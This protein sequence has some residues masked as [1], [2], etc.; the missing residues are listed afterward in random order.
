MLT[1]T[2]V[3]V[4]NYI[5]AINGDNPIHVR[6]VFSSQGI[7]LDDQD[8]DISK[9]LVLEDI[10][11]GDTDIAFGKAVMKQ[12]T[13]GILN[14]NRVSSLV[15]T[16]EF[17]L[18]IGVD[19]N[20]TTNYVKVGTFIGKQPQSINISK[21]INFTA[22]DRMVKFDTLADEFFEAI[23]YPTTVQDI[24]DDLCTF[25]GVTNVS[26]NELAN[27][28]SRS[29]AEAVFDMAGYTCRDI[30]SWIAE[31]CG[32]YAKINANGNV[33]M[34]WFT[35]HTSDVSIADSYEFDF[36]CA[37]DTID[38]IDR[39]NIKQVG[40]DADV[41]YPDDTGV[42]TYRIINNP[43]LSVSDASDVTTYIKPIYD[44]LDAFGVYLPSMVRCVGNW[45][46]ET[47]D[48][49]EADI[50]GNTV[51]MPVFARTLVFNGNIEDTYEAT[52]NKS[53]DVY[54]S[55]SDKQKVLTAKQIELI[56][57]DK[58]YERKSGITI[59]TNGVRI[60]GSKELR[61]E[62][63]GS[64]D[65][66]STNFKINS[67]DGYMTSGK[68]TFNDKGVSYYDVDEVN[69][70]QIGK[71]S[72][73]TQ[74]APGIYYNFQLTP[75]L[76][77]GAPI[78]RFVTGGKNQTIS[79]EQVLEFASRPAQDGHPGYGTF[80]PRGRMYLGGQGTSSF[81]GI[82][83]NNIHGAW[84]NGSSSVTE[85]IK[86]YTNTLQLWADEDASHEQH[87]MSACVEINRYTPN[88][89]S[90]E[91]LLRIRSGGNG[92]SLNF[93]GDLTG[94]VTGNCSGSAGSVA[95]GN[96]TNKP[97]VFY[98]G[99][100]NWWQA[101]AKQLTT[102][103]YEGQDTT[104]YKLPSTYCVVNVYKESNSRGVA[105]AIKWSNSTVGMWLARLHDDTSSS[106]FSSWVK[107]HTED[108]FKYNTLIQ[109]Y[110]IGANLSSQKVVFSYTKDNEYRN[111]IVTWAQ[112]VFLFTSVGWDTSQT[113]ITKTNLKGSNSMTI[114]KSY[115]TN[116]IV[117]T[118]TASTGTSVMSIVPLTSMITLGCSITTQA[119]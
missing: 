45:L 116:K 84:I 44:R 100:Y 64:I 20:G 76:L 66:D 10:M 67:T 115:T 37:D 24:Y 61:I 46:V 83:V 1:P 39:L 12:L 60:F 82:S 98:S 62:S 16:D 50:N 56:V 41:D 5:S 2:G 93:I 8:I 117:I 57:G 77:V 95:W 96:V 114:T 59:D 63:G 118:F 89:S 80:A 119:K 22:T 81:Y 4:Q 65:I 99:N 109:T 9:R 38:A 54:A 107:V 94:N 3:T 72:E 29:Y 75:S 79:H 43:F 91:R 58:Y 49:I 113:S 102:Y 87:Y 70:F 25:V 17:D 40:S 47:G 88:G 73:R 48:I 34:V 92:Y 13:V 33:Q 55:D 85:S 21:V 68:W 104:T 74:Y 30:L 86:I 71:W 7:T 26:G 15:W 52:G 111:F 106:N 105:T 36:D 18:E 97:T 112:D 31:A 108:D 51:S 35:D 19:I 69:P 11:N 90:G 78:V 101:P 42:N 27:I 23:T 28:M 53:R 103:K 6:L 14:S 110:T 32:C